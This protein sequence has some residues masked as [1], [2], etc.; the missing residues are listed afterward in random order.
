M[1]H[2]LADHDISRSQRI[3]GAGC[4]RGRQPVR[5]PV[6]IASPRR[7]VLLALEAHTVHYAV[8]IGAGQVGE[9]ELLARLVQSEAVGDGT[10]EAGDFIEDLPV[11]GCDRVGR[12]NGPFLE[13]RG[14]VA[15]IPVGEAYF[16]GLRVVE[17]D[18][19][20]GIVLGLCRIGVVGMRRKLVDHDIHNRGRI[21]HTRGTVHIRARA[22]VSAVGKRALILAIQTV[23][24]RHQSVPSAVRSQRPAPVVAIREL[25]DDRA[26]G[27]DEAYGLAAVGEL[28]VI[29]AG[30]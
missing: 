23:A 13:I 19:V 12:R 15:Q 29:G 17:L 25:G 18:P 14:A 6:R 20:V 11:F 9:E 1:I 2:E 26:E 16:G 27:S 24:G 8:L 5:V 28:A 7:S 3:G 21:R 10:V 4:E 22:P 30:E